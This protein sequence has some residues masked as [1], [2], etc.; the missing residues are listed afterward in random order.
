M[1]K[2]QKPKSEDTN[3]EKLYVLHMDLCGP[4]RVVSVNEKK[5]I[6]VTVDDY[7]RFTWV[8]CLRSKDEAPD[9][10]LREY[11][12]KF[13]ISHE[14]SVA[15]SPQQN[16]VVDIQNCTLIEAA[17]IML[18]YV[19]ASLFLWAEAVTT[20]CYTQ[21]C[22]IIRLRHDKT[23]YELLHDKLTDLSFFHVF[24]PEVIALIAEAVA[25]K[26]AALTG[27]PSSTNFD[28]DAPSPSN[29]QTILETQTPVISNDVDEDNNDLDVTHMNNDL[30]IGI[31]ESPKTPTF[32]ADPLH[33]RLHEDSTPQGSTSNIR[34]THSL[35]ESLE[36]PYG[37]SK[38]HIEIEADDQAIQTILL[39]LLE[40]IYTAVDSC[41]TAQEIW[42]RVQQMMKGSDI[43][44][45][46]KKAKLFNEWKRFTSI[47]GESIESYY[48]R[49]LKLINDLK[50]NEHF[51]KKIASNLKFLNN[52]QPEWS[53]HVTILHQTKDLHTVDYTQLYDFLKYNQKEN[54]ENQVIQNAVQNP[55]TQNVGNQNGLIGVPG[56][57]NQ[58]PNGN[59]NL[60]AARAES[61]AT[62]HN[63]NQIR[64]YN[65]KGVG[66]FARNCTVK[67]KRM[68]AAYLQT[69]L[70]IAQKEE[71]GIQLQAKEFDLMAAVADLDEIEEVNANC[72]LM[73]NLQQP[74]T[75][76]DLNHKVH[77]N[78][79]FHVQTDDELTKKELKQIEA[80]DQAIQ[81]ILLGLPE[82]IY[83]AVDSY[84]T[85]QEIWLRV[86]Q[87]MKGSDIEIQEKKAKLFNEWERFTSTD[88]EL[89]ES[90]Y[91]CFL[92]LMND[93]RRNKHFPEKIANNL[94]FLNN[95]QPEWSRHVTIV[96]QTKD[97]H[98]ADYT[99]L[100]DF[101]KYNQKEVDELKAERLGKNQDPLALMAASNNPY[102]FPVIHQDQPSFNQNY[103]QQPMPNPEDITDSTI[104]MNME[105]ALMAKAFKLNYST[106]TNNN[107]RISSNPRNRQ[108]AQPGLN[109]GQDRQMQMVGGN[110][111]NQFRQYAGQNVGNLNGYN[112]VQNVRNQN[113][114]GNGNLVAARAEGNATGH[115][116]NQIRCYNCRG[117][118]YFARNCTVR[119]RRMDAAYI[120]TQLL[121]A[122]KEEA[123]IQLQ[124]EEFDLMATEGYLD[125][126]EEVNANYI[127]MANLQ[128]TSTT[129]TQTDKA[130]VYDSDGSA[131]VHNYENCYHNEI[132]YMFTQEEQYTELL[133]LIPE[134][135]Q[136]PQNDNN[137]TY[138]G[139]SMEQSRGT[140]E[141]H[142]A[143]VEE[144]RVLY[145]SLYNNLAIEVEKVNTINCKLRETNA[146]LTTQLARYNQEKMTLETHNWSSSA[147]QEL[148]KIIKDGIFPIVNQVDARVQNFEIQ[149]LKETAKFVG[150]FK[151]LAKEA[152]ECLAKHKA[153]ELEIECLLRVVVSQDIMSIVQNNS[154][155]ETSNLQTELEHT[156][157]RFENCIIKKNN[158]Y[159]KLWNDWYKK[160]EE[161]KFDKISYDK[162]Y[163]DM[164]QKI[165]RLQAQLGNLKGKI[166][167]NLIPTLQGSKVVKNV[168]VIAPGMFRINSFKPS[169]E[170][171]HVP[172]KVKASVR[173]K[174]ITVSQ[175]PVITKKVVNSDSN[176]L[177][178]TGVDNTKTRRPQPR[179]NTKNDRVPSV[180]K[181]SRSK[182]TE[183]E[184]EEHHRK[185]L[186]S[187]N[188]KHMSSECNNVKLA[189]QNVKSKVVC[190]M[191]CSKHMTGNL[192]LLI[193]F[194]WK[195]LGTV[196]FKNDHVAVILGFGDLQWGNILI[197]RVYFIEGLGHNLFSVGQFCDSDLEVAFRRNACFIRNL[198]GVD[199]LFGNRTTNLY[200]INL[201]EMD[202]ASPICLMAR[203]S[204][205]K[206]WLWHQRLS[207]LNFDTINDLAKT[208][209]SLVFQNSNIIKNTFVFYVSK[210]KA[211]EH[212]IHPNLFQIQGRDE[213]PEV[214]KTFL[215]KITVLLQ[216]PI[217][218]I[219][220][221][222]GT[223]FKNQ[224]L[225][226][227]FDSVG[228]S[229]QVS[230]VIT[231]QQNGVVERRNQTLV[232]AAR[233][234]LIFSRAPLFL[235]AE[236]IAT[237][238][239]TQNR[240]I[241]H[242]RFNKTPYELI[243]GRKLDISFLHVFGALCYPK[244]DREDIGKLGA[245]G[246]IGFF[247]GYSADSCAYRVYNRRTKKIMETMN[248]SFNGLSAMDFEQRSELD[249][250]FE[251]MYDDYIGGQPSSA[252]RT[253]SAAQSHQVCQTPTTSTSIA[254]TTPTPTDSSSHATN[255]QNSSQDV[256]GLNSQ[257]QHAQQQGNQA[258]I[259]PEAVVDNV[260]NAMFDANTFVNPFAT[261]STKL[262]KFKR[263]DVWVLVLA[264]DN[265]TPLTLKWLF[266]NK[267]DEEKMIIRNKSRLVVR[268]Y[269]Q[270]EGIYFEESFAPV[271]RMEA[272]GIFLAYAAHK[273]FTVFQMDVKTAFL[274]GTLKKDVYVCQ[275]KGFIDVDHPSHV[276]MVKK[277]LYGLKQAQRAWYDELST[278]LLQNHFFKGTTDPTLFIRRFVD[279]ILVVQ[280]YVDDIFFGSTHPKYTQLFSELMKSRFGM[281]MME[282]MTFFL[283]LQFNQSPCDIF[284][285][286]SKYVLEILKKYGMESCDPVGTP[287]EIKDKLD[288]NQNGTPVDAT[289]YRSMIGALMY[290]TCDADYAGCK[291]TFKSTSGGA[292]F[293]G[294]KLL[295]DYGFHF[296]KI[297]IYCDSKSAI[298]ISCNPVQHSR[299]KHIAVCYHFIK[300]DVE[301]DTIELYFVKTDYQLADLFTKALPVDRFNYLVCRLGSVNGVT[302]SFQQSQDSR[303]HAQSTKKYSR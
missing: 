91:H 156:K 282:E 160:Y 179:S 42:L 174:P 238:C 162:A 36:I 50:Q 98:I 55:R 215:K 239:F 10:T 24:A 131:E 262:L 242:C 27:S 199:L 66:H 97:L 192:Q 243:N 285:N 299:T 88:G 140:V 170:E 159:A 138:E 39:G 279:N 79:T 185:L 104:E 57:A 30:F 196:R 153:L 302:T 163:N 221:D 115:N 195:F 183:V 13:S 72:I 139:S 247:I 231:P 69:Q 220:T 193:N 236:A 62:G 150:D 101:L 85:A 44:I 228:I 212:L 33:E 234:M 283:G 298:A 232:E 266:K 46:E 41:E 147:H 129:G 224:V 63:G 87:M 197:T 144:T 297:P 225:R 1:K 148:L 77:V 43:G 260:P 34:Q 259:Q 126:I 52:L 189:T 118:A 37:E 176:A 64:C 261:L 235:W 295:T 277:A 4:M 165:E 61:N 272:T 296:N 135:H 82:D 273:S 275:P 142:P 227:Y 68:D 26:P 21:I 146:E 20:A 92:K 154:V 17:R 103:M 207:H 180:S 201:H 264:P 172:N 122:Q 76:G 95:L 244:N 216:S 175:P 157:E 32:H 251:A 49:F 188:K 223:E 23:P 14:T 136:V 80:D 127:L 141:Q 128:Q 200:T 113:P 125:E 114:N 166:T 204:S 267:H 3:Q 29:S 294:K 74:L 257:Q 303:P 255:F 164:Q 209:L 202:S 226:E 106:P 56:N 271:A 233:T 256:D 211:K 116:G 218:I 167:S 121:I 132:F 158:E 290:L 149:F 65:Y 177:S 300:E 292:Q 59:G 81:T 7:S 53:R 248:V 71:A 281:S 270:E 194:V 2:P 182:N 210:E 60:V 9:Q 137:V 249:L 284:L 78:E 48:H 198:E 70:L 22:S 291:D 280:V 191:C 293:L 67:P 143:N 112:D 45:Q 73:A 253:V 96:H 203:A 258:P 288:L 208:I 229:H 254:D 155:V 151:S 124:A 111:K 119:P 171:K 120:Q 16:G 90:Y 145:D 40:D 19:K 35:F 15:R 109:M 12:E 5:Y 100:Y 265:I 47:D 301:K 11:Y 93:L 252:Q 213:A 130:P 117:L 186:L 161:C 241:I 289:K 206:S 105:L 287:M 89:I 86:Q 187:R 214:I 134:P 184:V 58:N 245:K 268:G 75:S 110:G 8:K 38:I 54:V 217:I 190:A 237:A 102:T 276:Y 94:K 219:R 18:I 263:L 133:K 123:G 173:T 278:F 168:K 181:S 84:E 107:Q 99:Q 83:A 250:L 286:Q 230:F 169:R 240:S 31:E 25:P 6:L 28:Q 205:T 178:S 108:I 246:D 269:R 222:N 274:H 152:D 51:P